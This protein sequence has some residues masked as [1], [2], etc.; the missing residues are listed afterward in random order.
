LTQFLAWLIAVEVLG[1]AF[2]PL[3]MWLL[4]WLPD[5]GYIFAK[6][7]G[8]L[9]VTYLTWIIGNFVPVAGGVE[10]PLAALLLAGG[11]GW[12]RWHAQTID[13]LRA[14]AR[15]AAVEELV[16]VGALLAWSV[17]RAQV[18]GPSIAHTEQFMDVM[19]LNAS[20]RDTS[21]PPIDAWMSGHT[22][23]YYYF[24]YLMFATLLKLSGVTAAVGYNLSLSSVFAFTA[25]GSYSLGYALI[26]K[27]FWPLLAPLFVALL[28]NW[29]AI[30]WQ[31]PH[32]GCPH[33]PPT[34]AFWG[35]L[36]DSTRV[37]G[38]HYTLSD[39]S[40][41]HGAALKT[42]DYTINEFP[43]FSLV[44]GDLH[45][46]V[47]A[48]PVALLAVAVGCAILFAPSGLAVDRRPDSIFRL[49]VMAGILGSLF[50]INSWD[51][52]T[53]L[54]VVSVCVAVKAYI[55]DPSPSWWK[56]PLGA[57]IALGACSLVLFAPFYLH[58]QSLSHGIGT[59]TTPTDPY[60]F[61]Q[62]LGFPVLVCALLVGTLNLLLRPA[63]EVEETEETEAE[64]PRREGLAASLT[65]GGE[66]GSS[67]LALVLTLAGVVLL[68]GVLHRWVLLLLLAFG[69]WAAMVLVRVINTDQPNLSDAAGLVWIGVAA[70]LLVITEL[71]YVRDSFDGSG[72]YRMNTVFKFYYHAWVLLGLAGAYGVYRAWKVLGNYFGR[73]YAWAAMA[74]VVAGALGAGIATRYVGSYA[75]A[76]PTTGSLDGMVWLKQLQPG[77]YAAIQWMQNHVK[78]NPVQLEAVGPDYLV[79]GPYGRVSAFTGL[80]TVMGWAGHEVQWRPGNPEIG[81]R[82]H[83][84]CTL[85]T[86]SNIATAKSLLHRYDVKYVF[87]GTQERQPCESKPPSLAKFV[88]F[89]KI[90]FRS[91]ST[92]VYTW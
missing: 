7:L 83:D 20:F 88:R 80:P 52:P 12:W 64:V 50:T 57:L 42:I 11:L 69:L 30:L 15:V 45:P 75:V 26:R 68:G 39:W 63:E 29:H 91:G 34:G 37:I 92:T 60:E 2:L 24:G 61:L 44:L 1:L 81:A 27:M 23:N 51:F 84:V 16:F 28:G 71:Y 47:M 78:G 5:R 85:Y 77:D 3:T 58:F 73:W 89:M 19:Y 74:I 4:R 70:L 82:Q 8:V 53:Y 54:L 22:V 65:K 55:A 14:M 40:C 18:F 49:L 17:L 35:W 21:Y 10:L 9:A 66:A 62:V 46:H 76:P 56:M 86:T 72:L 48:L 33:S 59:V 36:F 41:G 13:A 87:A 43:L 38:G 6:I 25:A 31:I 90:A 67:S 79:Q 32:G